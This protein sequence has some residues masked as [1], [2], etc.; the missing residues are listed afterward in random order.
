[1]DLVISF[2]DTGSMSSVRHQVR[3]EIKTLTKELFSLVPDMRIGIIIHNDYCDKDVLVKLPLTSDQARIANFVNK[4]T[5]GYGGDADECYE[6]ALHEMHS[7]FT[8]RHGVPRAAIMIGDCNPHNK[9]YKCGSITCQYDWQTE[10]KACQAAGIKVYTVK[11]L[12][13][14]SDAFYSKVAAL[15]G[16]AKLKLAQFSHIVQY[17]TAVAYQAADRLDEYEESDPTFKANFAFRN[18]FAALRGSDLVVGTL[19]AM[20]LMGRFQVL[21]VD[22]PVS[23]KDFV[24]NNGATYKAGRGFYEFNKREAIQD[25]K[26]LIL[27]NKNT[28]EVVSD[29]ATT[30]KLLGLPST[31]T[32]KVKPSE[33]PACKQYT[34]Y[35]QSTSYNRKLTEGTKFLYEL[36]HL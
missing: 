8:W 36:N 22:A 18:M 5:D 7:G 11:A 24:N 34:A 20:D 9:G 23:I 15:T 6:L 1:M 14:N 35:I 28:G 26:E 30:R 29:Q 16:A 10:A 32:A 3:R 21:E 12:S 25:Y 31:G 4:S 19:E 27:V 33:I 2:D 13:Y 17:I